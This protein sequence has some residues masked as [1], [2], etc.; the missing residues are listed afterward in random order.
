M[1]RLESLPDRVAD[2]CAELSKQLSA[3]LGPTLVSM[4]VHGAATFVDR[5]SRLGDVDT[6]AVIDADLP[7]TAW[8]AIHRAGTAAP[9]HQSDDRGVLTDDPLQGLL[10]DA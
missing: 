2:A 9:A 1:I 6:H 3:L 7:N 4:W 8:E 5:P 10:S